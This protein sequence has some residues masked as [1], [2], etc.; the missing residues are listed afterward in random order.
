MTRR[1][2]LTFLALTL[3][4]SACSSGNSLG[5]PG[6]GS[7]PGMQ[8][9][10]ASSLPPADDVDT[11]GTASGEENPADT[12]GKEDPNPVTPNSPEE[13]DKPNSG[14]SLKLSN[15]SELAF[16]ATDYSFCE[17]SGQT[18]TFTNHIGSGGEQIV[19]DVIGADIVEVSVYDKAG[20]PLWLIGNQRGLKTTYT[21]A[22]SGTTFSI[23]GT[24]VSDAAGKTPTGGALIATCG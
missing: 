24:W 2:A 15:G 1:I 6:E 8:H 17:V 11:D 21:T 13:E 14:I 18:A 12:P 9:S 20:Q 22:F 23:D 10:D 7:V 19:V 16:A 4:L 3:T 5:R